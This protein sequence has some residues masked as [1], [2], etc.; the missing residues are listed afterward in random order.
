MVFQ[1]VGVM[2][3][4]ADRARV[5]RK[6]VVMGAI[7]R[8]KIARKIFDSVG[9]LFGYEFIVPEEAVYGVA[10]GAV[11]V[12]DDDYVNSFSSFNQLMDDVDSIFE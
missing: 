4:L 2:A 10:I 12:G 5:T 11:L 6:I 8:S 1:N 9:E 3:I 7:G